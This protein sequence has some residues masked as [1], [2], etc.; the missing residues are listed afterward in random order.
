MQN[1]RG[2]DP[3]EEEIKPMEIKYERKTEVRKPK[4]KGMK[5]YDKLL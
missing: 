1:W 3:K 2:R 4:C 5:S